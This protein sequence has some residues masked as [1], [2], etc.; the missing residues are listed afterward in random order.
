MEL[1][2]DSLYVLVPYQF[3]IQVDSTYTSRVF[4]I[5]ALSASLSR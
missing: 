4:G 1:V 2:D 5:H 3:H